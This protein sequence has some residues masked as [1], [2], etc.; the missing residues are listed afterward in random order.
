MI[1]VILLNTKFDW[2]RKLGSTKNPFS[3]KVAHKTIL[4][5][6]L[7]YLKARGVT[8]V[9]TISDGSLPSLKSWRDAK[10]ITLWGIEVQTILTSSTNSNEE[11]LR[12]ANLVSKDQIVIQGLVIPQLSN[13]EAKNINEECFESSIASMLEYYKLSFEMLDSESDSKLLRQNVFHNGVV[14]HSSSKVKHCILFDGVKLEKSRNLSRKIITSSRIINP[15]DMSYEIRN[16]KIN[17]P[18][19]EKMVSLVFLCL[20][21]IPHKVF[22]FLAIFNL[23][24]TERV[25]LRESLYYVE[26]IE[27]NVLRRIYKGLRLDKYTLFKAIVFSEFRLL[28]LGVYSSDSELKS[29]IDVRTSLVRDP[30][31]EMEKEI[32]KN[33]AINTSGTFTKSETLRAIKNESINRSE[34]R[35]N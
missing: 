25:Y 13:R 4:E 18:L 8:K 12:E 32:I 21:A 15:Y 2:W 22:Q 23:F 34:A 7:E 24:N 16:K 5:Y 30:G 17:V 10:P 33:Y 29:I 6:Q 14:V 20:L 35:V 28:G 26:P 9:Y 19:I 1:G 3:L 11:T 27:R 31:C